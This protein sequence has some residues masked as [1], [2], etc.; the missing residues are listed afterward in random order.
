MDGS[1]KTTET[2]GVGMAVCRQDKPHK[3]YTCNPT[4]TYYFYDIFQ[5]AVMETG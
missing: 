2:I 1:A 5:W 3:D 4:T